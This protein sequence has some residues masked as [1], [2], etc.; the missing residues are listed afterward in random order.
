MLDEIRDM[1][2]YVDIIT[3]MV[4]YFRCDEHI[5]IF[6]IGV[7][8][9]TS[10][11]A[12]LRGLQQR[13]GNQKGHL[14][15]CDVD[16]RSL[17]VPYE[18]LLEYWTFYHKDSQEIEWDSPLD[19]LFIDGEHTYD[20]VKRDYEKYEPFVKDEGI[21]FLHDMNPKATD[22]AKYWKEID[23]PKVILNLNKSG[24]GIVTKI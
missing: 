11:K 22:A 4:K 17:A 21:I 23:Y 10:T 12:M 14:Y 1:V 5:D 16:D 19:I 3:Q 8:R 9:A 24:L 7:R 20:A 15:S 18:E 2:P 13:L 6:E